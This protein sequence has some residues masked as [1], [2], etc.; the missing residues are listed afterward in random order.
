MRR[1][2]LRRNGVRTKAKVT[3]SRIVRAFAPSDGNRTFYAIKFVDRNGPLQRNEV[4]GLKNFRDVITNGEP[5]VDEADAKTGDMPIIFDRRDLTYVKIDDA[6]RLAH[7]PF[8]V[9]VIAIFILAMLARD[10]HNNS[11]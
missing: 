1:F 11:F 4:G 7:A 9:I 5:G 2:L 10:V 6:R 8:I 3:G